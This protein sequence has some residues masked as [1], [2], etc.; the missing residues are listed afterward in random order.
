M[1]K[2]INTDIFCFFFFFL[3]LFCY[4][5]TITTQ[6]HDNSCYEIVSSCTKPEGLKIRYPFWL[7]D[8][9]SAYEGHH[10]RRPDG[11]GLSCSNNDT[12][13][14]S[15]ASQVT[16]FVKEIDYASR[17]IRVYDP[18]GCLPGR[19]LDL[20]LSTSPFDYY[21]AYD[22]ALFNC[23]TTGPNRSELG[24]SVRCLDSVFGYENYAVA[25]GQNTWDL[26]L[27]YCQKIRSVTFPNLVMDWEQ[28]GG[29]ALRWNET[30]CRS[31]R[32]KS[33]RCYD[34][35]DKSKQKVKKG[36]AIAGGSILLALIAFALCYLLRVDKKEKENRAKIE[37][38]LEDYRA[39]KPSRYSYADIKRVT[40]QFKYKLGQGGYGS[41]YRGRL[42]ND[43]LV[44]VKVL[45]TA[46]EDGDEFITEVGT[47]GRIYHINVVRLVGFC[48][49][50][51]R[52]A[53]VYEFLP[54]ESLDKFIF[55]ETIKKAV[56]W[57]KLKEIALGTAK[58]VEYLHRGCAQQI[59]HFDIKPHNIL[60]DQSFNPKIS[61][62]GLAKLCSKEQSAVSM[63]ALRGTPGYI[64]PEV[65]SRNFGRVSH[66]SDVYSFGMLL[67]DMVE[68]RSY[69][70]DDLTPGSSGQGYFPDWIYGRLEQ[71]Q[72][73]GSGIDTAADA[74]IAKQ[75][76]TV[77]LWCIQW[78]PMDRPSMKLVVQMLEGEGSDL[79]MP[80]NPFSTTN[81]MSASAS[82]GRIDGNFGKLAVINESE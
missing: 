73:I 18:K 61:D 41:V 45:N 14:D 46:M 8:N 7:K 6:S 63:T 53:L 77:G 13:L 32:T 79:T 23:S 65:F 75:L 9:I 51:N 1:S 40:D 27:S 5:P 54:N 64:A 78:Y 49:D 38:F 81:P 10:C 20:N 39:F 42:S 70:N 25:S 3:F 58:G 56:G 50:G 68:G 35:D 33:K 37:T 15:W 60:L 24:T 47:M 36:A 48:A 21:R 52:R 34:C 17:F 16:L 28:D 31:C 55:S 74:N 59:L 4:L 62:F 82:K 44:A 29:V 22:Y 72:V 11:F 66:K 30:N 2:V 12:V 76:T 67:I 19:L 43:V 57:K 80:P 26:P 71:G 69:H